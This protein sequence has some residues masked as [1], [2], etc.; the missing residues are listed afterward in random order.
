MVVAQA[1]Y[2]CWKL[3]KISKSGF[4]VVHLVVL[5]L[6]IHIEMPISMQMNERYGAA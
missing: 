2:C 6:D 5:N 4:S 3:G 1:Q